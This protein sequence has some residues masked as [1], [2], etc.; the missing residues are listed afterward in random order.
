MTELAREL[1]AL[2]ADFCY[3]VEEQH[4]VEKRVV[5]SA[6]SGMRMRSEKHKTAAP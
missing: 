1:G 2:Q 4:F 5:V 6:A 3:L